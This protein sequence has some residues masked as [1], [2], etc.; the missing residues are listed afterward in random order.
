VKHLK[1][2]ILDGGAFA[3][4]MSG[5]GSSV[6][7]LFKDSETAKRT[8]DKIRMRNTVSLT[9]PGFSPPKEDPD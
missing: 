9:E 8:M 4:S 5:S 7:G 2:A 1:Q 3:A 6:Y